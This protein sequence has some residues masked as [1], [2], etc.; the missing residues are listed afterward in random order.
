MKEE[1]VREKEKYLNKI[2]GPTIT[3]ICGFLLIL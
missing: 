1:I 3:L 2:R